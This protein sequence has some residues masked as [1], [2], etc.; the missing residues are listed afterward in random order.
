[1][2]LADDLAVY[3]SLSDLSDEVGSLDLTNNGAAFTTGKIADCA[4]FENS[5]QSLS[6]ADDAALRG[7]DGSWTIAAWL[8]IDNLAALESA[9]TKEDSFNYDY[10]LNFFGTGRVELSLGP[11]FGGIIVATS[12]L[13]VANQWHYIA[14]GHD[15]D[16]R[17]AFVSINSGVRATVSTASITLPT[18]TNALEIGSRA[19]KTDEIG[20]WRRALSDGELAELYNGGNGLSYGDITGTG[21]TDYILSVDAGSYSLTGQN[22]TLRAARKIVAGNGSYSLTGQN[23]TLTKTSATLAPI[24]NDLESKLTTKLLKVGLLQ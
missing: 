23:A 17:L 19:G 8:W 4:I 20:I 1:M 24:D 9:I 11:A 14:F 16:T 7:G 18:T 22:A 5:F 10:G 15:T 12:D 2:A 13:I 21:H 6:R 3:Y